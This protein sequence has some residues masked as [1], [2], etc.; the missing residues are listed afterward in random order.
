VTGR[1]PLLS[2][3]GITLAFAG[4]VALDDVSLDVPEGILL[5][6]IGPNGAGKSSLFNCVSGV[7]R[8]R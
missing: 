2:I 8:P 4:L 7:H 1:E 6:I 5:A 3:E